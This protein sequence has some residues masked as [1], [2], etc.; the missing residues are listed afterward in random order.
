M[1]KTIRERYDLKV[2][3]ATW[4]FYNNNRKPVVLRKS[5]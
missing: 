1:E 4:K 5:W 3:K 2:L